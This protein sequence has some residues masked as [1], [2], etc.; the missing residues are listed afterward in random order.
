VRLDVPEALLFIAKKGAESD[1]C[2]LSI[3]SALQ[4]SFITGSLV[5]KDFFDPKIVA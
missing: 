4:K 5:I 3:Y 1:K 2:I